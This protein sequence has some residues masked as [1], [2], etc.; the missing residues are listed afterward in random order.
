MNHNRRIYAG[1]YK[2]YDG[3]FI[4][5]ITTATDV[6]SGEETVVYT[7]PS[8]VHKHQYFTTTKSSFC[9]NIVFKG[10]E[11]PKYRRQ[12]QTKA[13]YDVIVALYL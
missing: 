9:E 4:Y 13:P 1:F 12:T 2:R 8:L 3:E 11:R 10:K 7:T 5:V 6:D